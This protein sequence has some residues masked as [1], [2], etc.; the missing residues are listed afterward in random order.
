VTFL[1][2]SHTRCVCRS[3]VCLS[4]TSWCSTKTIKRIERVFLAQ[5]AAL[6]LSYI[7]FFGP[8]PWGHS[9]PFCH[10]LSLLSLLSLM[11]LWTSMRRRRAPVATPGEWQCKTGGCGGS[12]WRMGPTFFKCFLFRKFVTSI[13]QDIYISHWNV[14]PNSKRPVDVTSV[15]NSRP[16]TVAGLSHYRAPRIVYHTMDVTDSV[17]RIR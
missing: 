14:V 5:L 17:A 3:G 11:L 12:Q 7:L 16:T 1:D 13:N 6:G 8:I 2:I 10:A 15:V 4:V 9:G